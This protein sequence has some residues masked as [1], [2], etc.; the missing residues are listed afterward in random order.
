M[1]GRVAVGLTLTLLGAVL[2]I[3]ASSGVSSID[4]DRS[5]SV[6]TANPEGQAVVTE[7]HDQTLSNGTHHNIE[8]VTVTN[9][10]MDNLEV[11]VE[12]DMPPEIS[13]LENGP[14]VDAGHHTTVTASVAC[15]DSQTDLEGIVKISLE[16]PSMGVE[17]EEPI[18]V[19]CEPGV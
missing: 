15:P 4:V 17:L 16:S 5:A 6:S 2:L 18:K 8:L 12:G 1:N 9:Q 19:T 10:H 14:S 13:R 3:G 7:R 11:T